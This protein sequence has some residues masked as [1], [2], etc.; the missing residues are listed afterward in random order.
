MPRQAQPIIAPKGPYLALQPAADSLNFI[1][2]ASSVSDFDEFVFTGRELLV[3]TSTGSYTFTLESVADEKL[4][5]G[6]VTAYALTNGEYASFWF[7]KK[8]GWEQ[9]GGK[10]YLKG[11]NAGILFAVVRIPE[12]AGI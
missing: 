10:V 11:S 1:F 4:R 12:T 8:S 6:D 2:T 9:S 7:G 3:V 5:T